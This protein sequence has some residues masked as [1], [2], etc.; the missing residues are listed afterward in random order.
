MNHNLDAFNLAKADPHGLYHDITSYGQYFLEGWETLSKMP[1]PS[2]YIKCSKVIFLGMGGSGLAGSLAQDLIENHVRLPIRLIN[3]Y[4]LPEWID[5]SSLI[6][7]ISYSGETEETVEGFVESYKRKAKL[8]AMGSGGQLENLSRKFG[9]PYYR[10]KP[11]TCGQPRTSTIRYL[12]AILAILRRLGLFELED[13]IVLTSRNILENTITRSWSQD[14]PASQNLA[15]KIAQESFDT[16]PVIWGADH[17]QSVAHRFKADFNENAKSYAYFEPIPEM[18]HKSIV[19]C[20]FPKPLAKNIYH[21]MLKSQFG[22]PHNIKRVKVTADF[23][24]RRKNR[25]QVVEF[26]EADNPLTETIL[27][28]TLSSLS[29]FY[30]AILYGVDPT[31]VEA[32]T[33]FKKHLK[34]DN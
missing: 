27:G 33:E 30:L 8:I 2:H 17:L 26:T 29:A 32:V 23:F 10:H 15:K 12:G 22:H 16:I 24:R 28:L 21:I 7:A 6:I 3:N 31:P 25:V 9:T 14:I 1:I 20:E 18:N 11:A 19:G 5:D 34:I 4:T 13:R